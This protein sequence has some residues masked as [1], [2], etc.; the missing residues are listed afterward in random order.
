M[1]PGTPPAP[2]ATASPVLVTG[3]S[4][5]IGGA[6]AHRLRADGVPVRALVRPTSATGHLRAAGVELVTGDI[7]DRGAVERA[8]EGVGR[9][10]HIAG[11]FR[12]AGHPDQYYFDVNA[13]GTEN[14]LHAARRHGV[15][16]LVHGST[17]GVHGDVLEIPCT[18]DS[19]FNPGDVY[20][21]S[22]LEGERLVQ[23]ALRDG[24]PGVV[25][26]SA[27]VY[28]PGDL[29]HLKLFRGIQKRR[30]PM[31]GDGETLWHPVYIDDLVEG[32]RLCAMQPAAL[33]RTYILASGEHTTLN[34]LV[35]EIARALGL[36]PPRL[37]LPFW[38]L[39]AAAATC[40]ALCRPLRIDPP[41]HRRRV[42][43]FVNNRAFSIARARDE[44]GFAPR[45]GV[46]EGVR[47]TVAW[48][49]AQ[50]LLA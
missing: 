38:P 16:R 30:F 19:P 9:I 44:L 10:Y 43:F 46:E 12:T 50:G 37:R 33:G 35:A 22:K 42:K 2:H 47:R 23:A 36:G 45:I 34:R 28:G 39:Y 5:C 27:S 18:E 24:L 21:R 29:R 8:A 4:G 15:A 25:Y 7:R 3:A 31:F 26:R 49:R 17:I 32:I 6:L 1:P 13:G 48:Y 14:V 40:E 20:Q 11:V 41:L